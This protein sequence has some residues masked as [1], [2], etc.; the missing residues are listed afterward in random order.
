[1]TDPSQATGPHRV[2]SED[3]MRRWRKRRR[4][5]RRWMRRTGDAVL[6]LLIVA[7]IVVAVQKT[8]KHS[9]RAPGTTTAT[10][11]EAT[12]PLADDVRLTACSY[13]NYAAIAHL[14]VTNHLDKQQNYYVEV[15]F[16]DGPRYFTSA[17]AGYQHLPAR[18]SV[19]VVAN[20]LTTSDPP[21]KLTCKVTRIERFG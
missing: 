1:M 2:V 3:V 16:K 5:L 4:R 20:T 10:G 8:T 19:K 18:K 12:H 14:T 21:T 17:I 9:S 7:V 6:V 15:T 11:V 13:V